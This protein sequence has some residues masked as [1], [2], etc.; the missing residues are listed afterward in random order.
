MNELGIFRKISGDHLVKAAFSFTEGDLHFFFLEYMEG[1]DLA[2]LLDREVY[3]AQNEAKF[4]IAEIVLAI[5]HLH[6][7][8]II[9]R[10]LKPHNLVLDSEGH[11]KLTDF[12]LSQE[13][14]NKVIQQSSIIT[15]SDDPVK[16]PEPICQDSSI[17]R[18]HKRKNLLENSSRQK[19][20]IIGTP[21]YIAPEV[22]TKKS[23]N[24]FTIDWWSLG[25]IIYE[26]LVGERPFGGQTID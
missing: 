24:N 26:M 8:N 25:V 18:S 11:L 10:D 23:A 22:L 21:D 16:E 3:L 9:H 15:A 13:G 7:L 17:N 19:G 5:E 4:Y 6:S 2:S 12:G 20:H 1:G 14:I